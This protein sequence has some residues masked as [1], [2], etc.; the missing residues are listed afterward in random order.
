MYALIKTDGYI[1]ELQ[2]IDP[3]G[4]YAPPEEMI[5]PMLAWVEVPAGWEPYINDDF[6][7]SESGGW[8]EPEP[9]YALSRAKA[10]KLAAIL[11]GANQVSAVVKARYSNP[12]IDSW[13]Q[14]EAEA[15]ALL[16]DSEAPAPLVRALAENVKTTAPEFA[17]RIVN[18]A[19]LAAA[20]TM[21]II[22]QQQSMEKAAKE[23]ENIEAA[24]AITVNYTLE[25]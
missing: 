15:R 4:R 6:T 12:E 8:V 24:L 10:E 7:W 3:D 9:D 17:Q 18:N 22:L 25:A 19:D 21:V 23:A 2:D 1:Q 20:A 13:Q 11:A 14:Q 16:A 5:P